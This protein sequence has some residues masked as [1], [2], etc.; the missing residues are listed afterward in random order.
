MNAPTMD[1]N[2]AAVALTAATMAILG[3]PTTP[4]GPAM[5][6]VSAEDGSA[7]GQQMD[8]GTAERIAK[9]ARKMQSVT[10]ALVAF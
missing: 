6:V 9:H 3:T 7:A 1:V 8:W 5:V 10:R 4:P 2:M